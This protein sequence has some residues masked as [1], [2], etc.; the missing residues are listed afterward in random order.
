VKNIMQPICKY[1]CGTSDFPGC[2]HCF[3]RK[4]PGP[5][6]CTKCGHKYVDWINYKEVFT[7]LEKKNKK[8]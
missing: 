4:K 1:R 2:G 8:E 6:V 5:I 3:E 7:Y